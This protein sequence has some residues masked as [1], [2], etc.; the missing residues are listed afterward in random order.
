[1]AGANRNG[2]P[3]AIRIESD[4]RYEATLALETIQRCFTAE[5]LVDVIGCKLTE[6][7][8]LRDRM[9]SLGLE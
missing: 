6:G 2:L 9:S 3:N 7:A 5:L 4:Q 8:A 1:M